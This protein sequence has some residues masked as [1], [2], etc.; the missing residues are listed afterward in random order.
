MQGI[1]NK[2]WFTYKARIQAHI[3]LSRADLHSQILLVWYALL[4]AGLAIVA[5]RYPTILGPN[6]DIISALLGVFLLGISM[7]VANRDFRGRGIAMCQNYQN[8]QRLYD[9]LGASSLD[10][11]VIGKYHDLLGQV[12]NH[13]GIDDKVFRV[14]HAADLC[15]RHPVKREYISAY[16]Y[17]IWRV[18]VLAFLYLSPLFII[19]SFYECC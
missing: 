9:S 17:L 4:S 3:R 7:A 19:F 2:I 12:E 8:L 10:D 16:G 14:L 18:V 11:D 13:R 1:K 15:S 5:I 6:T